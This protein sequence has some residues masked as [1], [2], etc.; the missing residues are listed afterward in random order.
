MNTTELKQ[1]FDSTENEAPTSRREALRRT[2]RIGA[3][4]AL[5]AL[6]AAF[7]VPKVSF[8]QD[9]G[10]V[11]DSLNFALTLEYL[12]ESFYRQGTDSGVISDTDAM[13]IFE[14][15]EQHEA[16]HVDFLSTAIEAAGGEPVEFTDD[17]FDFTAGG[18]FDPFNDYPTFLLLSQGF[19]D[20]GVRAY[21]GQAPGI[22]RDLEVAGLNVLTAALQIHAL[23]ARHAAEVRRLRA[24]GGASVAPWILL[25]SQTD[26]TPLEA[27]YGAGDPADMFPPEENTVQAGIDVSNF[28]ILNNTLSQEAATTAAASGATVMA[29]RQ[30]VLGPLSSVA[31]VDPE[32]AEASASFD[33]P[34]DMDTVLGIASPFL[35]DGEAA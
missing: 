11:I 35:A 20:T 27:V 19:E 2:G 21:K 29:H 8:A 7:L 26:G 5:V 23:E 10:G 33:E 1:L 17:D 31:G 12:E 18:N 14:L 3:G 13:T 9:G 25:D 15:I 6:P 34:L 32:Q 28:D 24:A 16:D 30:A 4:L 22:P